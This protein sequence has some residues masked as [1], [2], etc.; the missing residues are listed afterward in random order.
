MGIMFAYFLTGRL[1][2]AKL[3][4]WVQT[5]QDLARLKIKE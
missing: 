3:I 4:Q 2:A 5:Q 1:E